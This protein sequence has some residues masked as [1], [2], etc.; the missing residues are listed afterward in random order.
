MSIVILYW[1]PQSWQPDLKLCL[2]SLTEVEATLSDTQCVIFP[3]LV[4][5]FISRYL[6]ILL[7]VAGTSFHIWRI[8]D[9][10]IHVVWFLTAIL[11][12]ISFFCVLSKVPSVWSSDNGADVR[13]NYKTSAMPIFPW[14]AKKLMLSERLHCLKSVQIRSYFPHLERIRRDCRYGKIRTRNNSVFGHFSRSVMNQQFLLT[15][16]LMCFAELQ[17]FIIITYQSSCVIRMVESEQVSSYSW[18]A[19]KCVSLIL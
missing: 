6:T 17:K 7:R 3:F 15:S 5:V 18:Q 4:N 12:S 9:S 19:N 11:S 1:P 16:M 8:N 14:R 10:N 13:G 2:Q